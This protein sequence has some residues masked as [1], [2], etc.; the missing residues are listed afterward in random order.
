[1]R[2]IG[3]HLDYSGGALQFCHRHR[4]RPI[5][6]R[7]AGRLRPSSM[8]YLFDSKELLN[9]PTLHAVVVQVTTEPTDRRSGA[10]VRE[11]TKK[12]VSSS[13]ERCGMN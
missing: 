13:E 10:R 4:R 8:P 6:I 12:N 1:M 5:R 2:S 7:L 9:Q 3:S 11:R